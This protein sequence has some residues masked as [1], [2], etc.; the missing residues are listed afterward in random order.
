[1]KESGQEYFEKAIL[2]SM[3]Q[4]FA[5]EEIAFNAAQPMRFKIPALFFPPIET[6][7]DGKLVSEIFVKA[8][9]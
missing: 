4:E 5:Q 7:R 2:E 1:M 8:G 9:Q 6:V 3:K